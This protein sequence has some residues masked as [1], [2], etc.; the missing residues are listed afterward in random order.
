MVS[1]NL[2]L[3]YAFA[4]TCL[5]CLP[6]SLAYRSLFVL[7]LFFVC[8]LFVL[9][10]FFA[11]SVRLVLSVPVFFRLSQSEGHAPRPTASAK[12]SRTATHSALALAS[13][14]AHRDS[15]GRDGTGSTQAGWTETQA[16]GPHR[17]TAVLP[18]AW[19]GWLLSPLL[20]VLLLILQSPCWIG[21]I[22]TLGL[23]DQCP[24]F[25][26]FPLLS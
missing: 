20:S 11:C 24:L 4:P 2:S 15:T 1:P 22:P 14:P 19:L 26:P 10:L 12:G 21:Q 16:Q 7:S 13:K 5:C 9:C 6:L 25:F 17:E 3:L 23:P 18:T 8:S